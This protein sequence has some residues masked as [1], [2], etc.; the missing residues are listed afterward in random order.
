MQRSTGIS[1]SRR[2]LACHETK[3]HGHAEGAEG[4][5]CGKAISNSEEI[6]TQHNLQSNEGGKMKIACELCRFESGFAIGIINEVL[7]L[8]RD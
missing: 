6:A 4:P 1:E 2:A 3:P 7:F 5:F 8:D